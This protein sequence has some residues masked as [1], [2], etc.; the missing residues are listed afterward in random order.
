MSRTFSKMNVLWG[1]CV[2]ALLFSSAWGGDESFR[3]S[4]VNLYATTQNVDY[5]E[6]WKPGSQIQTKGCG[7]IIAGHRI[8]T[9]AHLINKG[10]YIEVQKFGE[11][12]R[13]VA[14]VEKLGFDLDL[15]Q[16][17][18]EDP[19]FFT[20]AKPVEFGELPKRGDKLIVQGGNELAIKEDSVSGMDMVWC[21]EG[22]HMV[23]ALLT[24]GPI[25]GTKNGCPVF[26][27]GKCVGIPFD[28]SGK[29]DKVGS[30][31]PVNVIQRFLRDI[32]SGKDYVGLPDLGFYSQDLE[33]PALRN[34]SKI[35]SKQTGELVGEVTYGGSADGFLKEGDILT[36][37]DG[38][39]VD[40]DGYI[41]LEKIG[42]IGEYYLA[43]FY[44]IGEKVDLDILRDGQAMKIKM[45]LK[46]RSQL[47]AYRMDNRHP[48]YF[49][50]A[51]FV[52]VPLTVNY[53]STANWES[54]KPE[55][56]EFFFHGSPSPERKQVVLI[57]HVLPHEI[58][59]GYDKMTNL[60]VTKINGRPI[61]E[62]K[63]VLEAF[64]H[65]SGKYHT[66][67]IDDFDWSGS[68]IV[69]DAEKSKEATE[70]IMKTFRIPVD[71]SADLK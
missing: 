49:V 33:N 64:E 9:T 46:A 66:I 60:V 14:K 70:E 69:V 42:R 19:D 6:P 7:T 15:A 20:D 23:P 38:H 57:S 30:L 65:P 17:T 27:G 10:N 55:L 13:Y 3:K 28:S 68:T 21:N 40:D 31:I 11:T 54:F 37:I 56:Q 4:V 8:L 59:K 61:S 39:P 35:S 25:D 2:G 41:D 18:V 12:K 24:N 36:A 29:T 67:E 51:G 5:Y 48:T 52:F 43:T 32:Q 47:L 26:S 1:L 34:F 44:S 62:M 50:M 45:P 71:R 22:G 16:L 53:F 63:D 58:N